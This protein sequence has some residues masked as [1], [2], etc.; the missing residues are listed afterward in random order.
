MKIMP[1]EKTASAPLSIVV[2]NGQAVHV[3]WQ[4]TCLESI[5][6]SSGKLD[7]EISVRLAKTS[8]VFRRLLGAVFHRPQ[9][10]R[11][12]KARIYNAKVSSIMLYSSETWR[13]AQ[14]QLR[15]VD[16]VQARHLR[17]VESFKCYDKIR[18]TE[19]L[20][21]F[22]LA[23]LSTQV[24]ARSLRWYGH[25]LCPP[26]STPKRIISDFNPSE[27]GW[28]RPRG[29]PHTRWADVINQ[30]LLNRNINPNEAPS[31]A[32]D[33][34]TWRRLTVLSTSSLYAGDPAEQER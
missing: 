27:N 19:I 33:R 2:I 17:R 14:T 25:L 20:K 7:A 28:K 9:I 23:N 6:S 32:L 13:I 5:I 8:S 24:E 3:V 10:N 15:M 4:F 12:T 1:I 18:N 16:A 21:T 22:K 34:A 29:R 11:H 30:R 26:I 31:L